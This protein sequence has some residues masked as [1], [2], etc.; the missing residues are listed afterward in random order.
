MNVSCFFPTART[1]WNGQ[2]HRRHTISQPFLCCCVIMRS[3]DLFS[4]V[5]GIT[6]GLRGLVKPVAYCDIDDFSQRCLATL[7]RRGKIPR[8]PVYTD[9]RDLKLTKADRVDIV[10]GGFP[11]VGFSPRGL[12]RGL[13]D[14]QSGLWSEMLRVVRNTGAPLVFM[15]NVPQIR[16]KGLDVVLADLDGAGYTTHWCQVSADMLG[17]PQVRARWFALAVRR[18]RDGERALARAAKLIDGSFRVG[19]F[20][21]PKGLE[22]E[23]RMLPRDVADTTPDVILRVAALGNAVVPD[24]VRLAMK[25]LVVMAMTMTTATAPAGSIPREGVYAGKTMYAVQLPQDDADRAAAKATPSIVLDPKAYRPPKEKGGTKEQL[26]RLRKPVTLAHW[27]TPRYGNHS[28]THVLTGR[29]ARDLP[30]QLRFEV[31]TPA[32]TRGGRT[33]PE[34]VEALMGYPRGWTKCDLR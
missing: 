26:P 29:S 22:P 4:G 23:G 25:R 33:N 1:F 5:G 24:A 8:A 20:R 18:G 2:S 14:P 31:R 30:T 6:H 28:G 17:A 11:C 16:T 32:A 19:S 10:T 9:V 21:W 3:V 12:R 15:E 34:W 27:A 7:M 13:D